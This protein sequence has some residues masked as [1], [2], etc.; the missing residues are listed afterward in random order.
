M[1]RRRAREN[2][3]VI[4]TELDDLRCVRFVGP[5]SNL[6]RQHNRTDDYPIEFVNCVVFGAAVVLLVVAV[7]ADV[8]AVVVVV[9]D[10]V[11]RVLAA[12]I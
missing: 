5:S 9:L 8:A 1:K 12:P 11:D 6:T 7:V 3:F 10:V 2:R 4:R